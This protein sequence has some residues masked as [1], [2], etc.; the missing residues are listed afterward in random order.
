MEGT[1]LLKELRFRVQAA[2]TVMK[3]ET[4]VFIVVIVTAT[5][6]TIAT[7]GIVVVILVEAVAEEVVIASNVASLDTLQGNALLMMVAGGIGMVAGTS[8]VE[9][10][11]VAAMGLIV[12]VIAILGAVMEE[13]AI[14]EAMTDITVTSLVLMNAPTEV[15]T[16][17]DVCKAV[18][19]GMKAN[20]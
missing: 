10:M 2:G 3:S 6:V 19:S 15:N 7:I 20:L 9:A 5:V 11:V 4:I 8:M 13:A 14:V 1:S 16:D 17:L 18:I 12:V